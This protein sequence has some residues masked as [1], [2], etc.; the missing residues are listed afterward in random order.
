M[1]YSDGNGDSDGDDNND[2]NDD[3]AAK[4]ELNKRTFSEDQIYP[5]FSNLKKRK[6]GEG[7]TEEQGNTEE[8]EGN[9][10]L[11][12]QLTARSYDAVKRAK[13]Q[14]AADLSRVNSL[15][16][17]PTQFL[18]D[19]KHSRDEKVKN[20]QDR[21]TLLTEIAARIRREGVEIPQ[22]NTIVTFNDTVLSREIPR[23]LDADISVTINQAQIERLDR[24][25]TVDR[26]STYLANKLYDKEF[27]EENIFDLLNYCDDRAAGASAVAFTSASRPAGYRKSYKA[28]ELACDPDAP[29][30]EANLRLLQKYDLL[31]KTLDETV[32]KIKDK[33]NSLSGKAALTVAALTDYINKIRSDIWIAFTSI[34][35]SGSS[36]GGRKTRRNKRKRSKKR[37]LS[38]RRSSKRRTLKKR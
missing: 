19:K 17:D 27:S 3:N 24:M 26:L 10:A 18:F 21:R 23:V 5:K 9:M 4:V 15:T 25:K 7:N 31:Q 16:G 22:K 37:K 20:I 1:S 13:E 30:T 28:S 6:E 36:E 38:K 34:L 8:V 14:G 12:R 32:K 33:R 35:S 11:E 29:F 2:N